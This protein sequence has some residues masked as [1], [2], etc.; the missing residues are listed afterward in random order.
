[1]DDRLSSAAYD[2]CLEMR[3][4]PRWSDAINRVNDTAAIAELRTRCPGYT[5][6]EYGRAI[7][8]G[9]MASR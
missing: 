2:L 8:Q 5:D 1:M 9:M 7:A 6:D 4:D 3:D